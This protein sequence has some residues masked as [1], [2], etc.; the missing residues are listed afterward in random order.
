[1]AFLLLQGGSKVYVNADSSLWDPSTWQ[2]NP[3]KCNETSAQPRTPRTFR[4]VAQANA[5][6]ESVQYGQASLLK[7][8]MRMSH[9]C[10]ILR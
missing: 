8:H 1:M 5:Y 4:A 2:P 6:L 7:C 10:L 9:G 3:K